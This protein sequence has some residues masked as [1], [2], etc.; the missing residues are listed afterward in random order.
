MNKKIL[1]MAGLFVFLF[2]AC[3][4][5]SDLT[6]F[7]LDAQTNFT[8]PGAQTGIGEILSIPRTEVQSSFEQ[9]FQNN[10]T[11]AELVKEAMLNKLSFT[12]TAPSQANFDF[13]NDIKIYIK[14]EGE[15]EILIALK[16]NI[17][18]DGSRQLE[19]ETTGADL[20]AYVKKGSFSLRT[21]ATT[22]KIVDY[23]VDVRV[24]MTFGVTAKVF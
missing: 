14:A 1:L 3:E 17:A 22:D 2:S 8:I 11:K 10:N 15:E 21:A 18:E 4:K 19:L 20:S 7:T 9:S 23:D 13:L 16:E 24:D 5:I 6:S 12:I